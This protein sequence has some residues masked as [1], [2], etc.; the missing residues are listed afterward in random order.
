MMSLLSVI[1]MLGSGQSLTVARHKTLRFIA[2]RLF[3]SFSYLKLTSKLC[4]E[5]GQRLRDVIGGKPLDRGVFSTPPEPK[6][7]YQVLQSG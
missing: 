1:K 5:I 2:F 7:G 3:L 6:H 4:R